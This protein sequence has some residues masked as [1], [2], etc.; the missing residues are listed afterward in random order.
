MINLIKELASS[1]FEVTIIKIKER[2]EI[3]GIMKP[4]WS[5]EI[6]DDL[7][8]LIKKNPKV[9]MK[10]DKQKSKRINWKTINKIKEAKEDGLSSKEAADDLGLPLETVNKYWTK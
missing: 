7:P 3:N 1:G 4:N 2:I 5:D 8:K 6:L 10:N 9:K